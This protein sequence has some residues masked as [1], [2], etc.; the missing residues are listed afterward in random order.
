[1]VLAASAAGHQQVLWQLSTQASVAQRP[2][3][4]LHF[5]LPARAQ[6]LKV[7]PGGLVLPELIAFSKELSNVGLRQWSAR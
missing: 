4:E 2:I 6:P 5:V 7:A 3:S 1:M